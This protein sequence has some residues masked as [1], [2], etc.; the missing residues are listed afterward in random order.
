VHVVAIALWTAGT[1]LAAPDHTL[2]VDATTASPGDTLTLTVEGAPAR[3]TAYLGLSASTG[4]TF[5]PAVLRGGCLGIVPPVSLVF[6][7]RTDRTGAA[8][9]TYTI[10]ADASGELHFE[11]VVLPPNDTSRIP[12]PV[13]VTVCTPQRWYAD[14]DGDGFGVFGISVSSCEAPAGHVANPYDCDDADTAVFPGA[15]E[16]C[17]GVDN[18]C[19]GRVDD[20][21][22]G[23][24]GDVLSFRDA[25]GDGFGTLDGFRVSCAL[26]P[27]HVT[28]LGDCDDD[29][30][31]AF[32]GGTEVCDGVDNDCDGRLNEGVTTVPDLYASIEAGIAAG[33]SELCLAPGAY[34]G[35]LVL[36]DDLALYG[37]GIGQTVLQGDGTTSLITAGSGVELALSGLTVTGGGGEEGGG[38]LCLGAALV[39][40]GVSFEANVVA[41]E[42]A[43]GGPSRTATS[44]SPTACSTTTPPS[45]ST[46][47]RAGPS[48]PAATSTSRTP[49]SS[50]TPSRVRRQTA[51][52]RSTAPTCTPR[53]PYWSVCASRAASRC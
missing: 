48:P 40:D 6:A 49:S 7:G 11:S 16:A 32:P 4:D 17:D 14:T 18:D 38:V 39:A 33:A 5:C 42:D 29:S 43:E 3:A 2:S 47:R 10:P 26:P 8:S 13:T 51:M 1:A 50:T 52:P 22:D 20:D 53:T 12:A 34:A 27:G 46:L 9:A 21:D 24:T 36:A 30:A 25:D 15:T 45:G 41:G 35:P 19:D 28:Q 23:V 44:S 31:D 37:S